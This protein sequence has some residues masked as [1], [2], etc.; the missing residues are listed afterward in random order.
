MATGNWFSD[1]FA[2]PKFK[3]FASEG[4]QDLGYGLANSTNIGNAF[5]SATSRM[6]QMQP[7]RDQMAQQEA[8]TAKQ[9]EQQ[10]MTKEWL[11]AKGR[12]DLLPLVDAGQGMFALQQATKTADAGGIS[13]MPSNVQEWDYY[14]KLSPDQQSQYLNMKRANT[15]LNIGTGFVTQ[16]QA[17]P[18]TLLGAPIA[19]QNEQKA[20]DT[21]LGGVLGT[22]EGDNRVAAESVSSKLPGLRTVIGELSNLAKT[23]TYTQTGQ[24]VDTIM[25]ETGQEPSEAAI[26]RAKYIAAVDNQVLPLLRDTFG[27]AFTQKEGET[28]RA[29]LGNPNAS[30]AEKQAILEAFIAQK[31]R[32]VAGMQS[33][34]DRPAPSPA[35]SAGGGDVD[36]ILKKYGVQ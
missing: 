6:G 5:G 2:N 33:R 27:A 22:A 26:A 18:G 1:A 23:A 21:N 12:E 7:Y 36:S 29:T 25:R 32:D 34:V 19:I 35:P 16:D 17:N 30:P 11:R 15:P 4:L 14:S 9:A 20:Y 13:S 3:K 31:E 10:N 8:A 28:L 24:L